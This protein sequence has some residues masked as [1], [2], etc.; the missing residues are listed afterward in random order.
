MN[1]SNCGEESPSMSASVNSSPSSS[2]N[3]SAPVMVY[4]SPGATYSPVM[5]PVYNSSPSF[6]NPSTPVVMNS[7]SSFTYPSAVSPVSLVKSQISQGISSLY[8]CSANSMG[9]KLVADS[10]LC[11]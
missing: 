2:N 3:S 1:S 7:S 5:V 10:I 6:T 8:E 9:I 4:V 11:S